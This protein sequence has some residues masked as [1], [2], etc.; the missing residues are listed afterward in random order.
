MQISKGGAY[1][2]R[3]EEHRQRK[4]K[5]RD[6]KKKAEKAYE[7]KSEKER[8]PINSIWLMAIGI[9]LTLLAVYTWTF[10]FW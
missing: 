6:E 4:E 2:D 9:V 3:Q 5:E 1:M 8:L 7:A 10:W